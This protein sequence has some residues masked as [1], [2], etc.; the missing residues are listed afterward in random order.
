MTPAEAFV[1]RFAR[2]WSNPDPDTLDA[3]LTPDVTLVQPLSAPTHGLEAARAAFRRLFAIFPDLRAVVDRWGATSD[4]VLIE[5]RLRATLGGQPLEWPAVD[6][7]TLRGDKASERV[8][9]FDATALLRRLATHPA[10]AWRL[11]RA[12]AAASNSG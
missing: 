6:R 11:W 4:G 8:S 7:F 5:L 10:V 12:G 1:G 3:L 9:Y 2:Y